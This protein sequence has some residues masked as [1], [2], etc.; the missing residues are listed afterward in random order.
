MKCFH[1][2]HPERC[3]FPRQSFVNRVDWKI[4]AVVERQAV[5]RVNREWRKNYHHWSS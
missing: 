5:E 3:G 2:K 4:Q 1:M